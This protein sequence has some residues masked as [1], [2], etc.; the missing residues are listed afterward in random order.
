MSKHL[1]FF[2]AAF[3]IGCVVALAARAVWFKPYVDH[4]GHPATPEYSPMVTN[5]AA[6]AADPHAEH[7]AT[8][9]PALMPAPAPAVDPHADHSAATTSATVN[10]HCTI[11]G[12]AVDPTVPPV[13]YQGKLVGFGCRLCPPKFVA[14]P[15]RYGPLALQNKVLTN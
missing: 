15:D 13:M 2:V 10:D 4:S 3:A 7:K 1:F 11:C 12:M 6:P 9:N 8:E 14:D 5:P